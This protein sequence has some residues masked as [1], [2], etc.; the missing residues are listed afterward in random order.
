[1][2]SIDNMICG[3][4]Y[5]NSWVYSD[6]SFYKRKMAIDQKLYKCQHIFDTSFLTLIYCLSS[7]NIRIE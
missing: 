7:Y 1:M 2:L 4:I 5:G 6:Q 3:K